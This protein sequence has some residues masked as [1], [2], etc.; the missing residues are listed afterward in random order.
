MCATLGARSGLETGG[1]ARTRTAAQ[2]KPRAHCTPSCT[3]ADAE[4]TIPD[5]PGAG[6][7]RPRPFQRPRGI[8]SPDDFPRT[9]THSFG[10]WNLI[11]FVFFRLWGKKKKKA[12]ILPAGFVYPDDRLPMTG[13]GGQTLLWA[14]AAPA[15]DTVLWLR[16]CLV[17]TAIGRSGF[18]GADVCTRLPER[19]V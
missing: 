1:E 9:I 10:N 19:R 13:P 12:R 8:G 11:C 7:C 6:I 3:R 14:P 2:S 5:L 17:S 4:P 16:G 15:G 18:R